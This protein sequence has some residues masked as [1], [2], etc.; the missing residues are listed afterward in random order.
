MKY[1][2][3]TILVNIFWYVN[4]TLNILSVVIYQ[5]RTRYLQFPLQ[6][7][8][9]WTCPAA[10]PSGCVQFTGKTNGYLYYFAVEG[11]AQC[12]IDHRP[13]SPDILGQ[14]HALHSTKWDKSSPFV[15][16]ELNAGRWIRAIWGC[17]SCPLC[18][19]PPFRSTK[20]N[21]LRRG[22]SCGRQEVKSTVLSSLFFPSYR[23]LMR[24]ILSTL[25]CTLSTS[26]G[27][28]GVYPI[29]ISLSDTYVPTVKLRNFV[30]L[31]LSNLRDRYFTRDI[32]C[33]NKM[34]RWKKMA[35]GDLIEWMFLFMHSILLTGYKILY[36]FFFSFPYLVRF[37]TL[38][39]L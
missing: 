7:I 37:I 12:T 5:N 11:F 16:G 25:P 24:P 9:S 1:A 15:R 38:R 20:R 18:H 32:R 13:R 19:S 33:D 36:C 26:E 6:R 8:Q 14:L 21:V 28:W 23:S 22:P 30:I 17:L 4:S 29:G 2:K 10:R 39:D 3:K 27:A 35:T 31:F 34:E